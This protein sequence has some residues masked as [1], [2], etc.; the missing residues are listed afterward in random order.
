MEV[1]MHIP[2]IDP[3]K[4]SLFA[5]IAPNNFES[6]LDCLN[7]RTANFH[8]GKYI[9]MAG[10]ETHDIGI[11]LSGLATVYRDDILGNRSVIA[12][13][14]PFALF[15]ES[16][17][18]AG[19]YTSPVTVE[20]SADSKV[21][22]VAFDKLIRTCPAGCPHHNTLIKNMLHIIARKNL[23][24]N[25]K[26][27]HLS[28]KTSRQK[29]ASYLIGQVSQSHSTSFAVSLDRQ[30]L[31]DYLCVNR[32]ALSRELSRISRDGILSYHK[33][34]FEIHDLK[35]LEGILHSE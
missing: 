13:I 27:D 34:R 7:A 25:A 20:A 15:A 10:E 30:G 4:V 6:M 3:E 12:V 9:L 11:L 21:L 24:L 33:N 8:R 26:I 22:S 17:V 16:F 29:L 18:C 14:T 35:R 31:A 23:S 32:S 2:D 5:G 28:K 19:I 1:R